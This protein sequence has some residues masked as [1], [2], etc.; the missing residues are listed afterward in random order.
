MGAGRRILVTTLRHLLRSVAAAATVG[1]AMAASFGYEV[2]ARE[3]ARFWFG[4][5]V[6]VGL[7]LTRNLAGK[8]RKREVKPAWRSE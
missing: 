7:D 8:P 3:P 1:F 2:F 6:A 5:L 4:I